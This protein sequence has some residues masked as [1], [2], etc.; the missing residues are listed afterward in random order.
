V[1]VEDQIAC[2]RKPIR[3]RLGAREKNEEGQW[4]IKEEERWQQ[5]VKR[6]WKQEQEGPYTE[7]EGQQQFIKKE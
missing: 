5:F 3:R 1:K 2:E 7:E 4:P 6:E